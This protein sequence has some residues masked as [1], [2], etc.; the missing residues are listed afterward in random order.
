M[1]FK[2]L[3]KIIP[4]GIKSY[5]TLGKWVI[6]RLPYAFL[7]RFYLLKKSSPEDKVKFLPTTLTPRVYWTEIKNIKLHSSLPYHPPGRL[8]F[9]GDWD[10]DT[11]HSLP[12][13]FE[14]IP[15]TAKKW[16]LHETIR[17]MFLFGKHYTCTPQ[18]KSMVSAVERK[19]PNPPQGCHSLK[20]VHLYF[21]QLADAFSSMQSKGYL[22]QA[23]LGRSSTGEIRLHVTRDGTLCLGG[24]GNHRIRMAELAGI[25]WVPFQLKGVHPEFVLRLSQDL[26]LPPHKA[27]DE[28]IKSNFHTQKP[29]LV[30]LN[31]K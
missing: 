3:R 12:S 2:N 24:G 23:E 9:A 5:L 19:I 8:C 4:A 29:D 27:I 16:D 28:W 25:K 18:Y 21:E 20:E 1:Y 11:T 17:A 15:T 14:T 10:I 26:R 13:I 6:I 7:Y 22:T 31:S 30:K